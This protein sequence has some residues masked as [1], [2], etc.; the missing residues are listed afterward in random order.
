MEGLVD[1]VFAGIAV[2][3][4]YTTG[5]YRGRLKGFPQSRVLDAQDQQQKLGAV[6]R[7]AGVVRRFQPRKKPPESVVTVGRHPTYTPPVLEKEL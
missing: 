6:E 7:V 5:Y 1:E 3:L 4:A 2:I